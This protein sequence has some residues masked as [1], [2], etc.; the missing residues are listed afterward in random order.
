MKLLLTADT[1]G[2]VFTYVEELVAGVAEHGV[3]IS[4][5][6]LGPPPSPSQRPSLN[7]LPLASYHELACALEWMPNPWSDVERSG[8]WL[9][10]LAE[11]ERPDVVHLNGYAHGRLPLAAPVVVVGHSCVLSWH[12]A[13]R[14]RP[15]GREWSAYGEAVRAGLNGADVLVAPTRALLDELVRLYRAACETQVIPNGRDARVLGPREGGGKESVG[16]VWPREPYV[17]GAGRVWD[18]AK[19]LLA[20][21]R[22]APS[23]P[24]PVRIAGESLGVEA[25]SAELLGHLSAPALMRLLR[26]AGIYA[27]PARY[28]PFG[29]GILEAGLAGCPL[30]LG[31]IA[32]LR[33][34]WDGAAV[35][36]DPF[37]DEALARALTRLIA[38][39]EDRRRLGVAARRRALGYSRARMAGM[40][41]SLYAQLVTPTLAPA[42]A[43]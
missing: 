24:W 3:E 17:L 23:L 10:E 11:Q 5:A 6:M 41:A 33:E 40:Y 1:V 26:S 2:G 29:L 31:D 9:L 35:F 39:V 13:V 27:A 20:L 22:I 34:T 30:V 32:S 37:D 18:E 8:A 7:A 38:R 19:N 28:E 43:A 25:S 36:V 12:D 21:D 15:A 14:R 42:G 16:P 4:L